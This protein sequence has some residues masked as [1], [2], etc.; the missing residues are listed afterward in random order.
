M[1]VC[2]AALF[3]LAISSCTGFQTR[4]FKTAKAQSRTR[5]VLQMLRNV[6]RPELLIFT[7]AL[8]AQDR[9]AWRL[10]DEATDAD[11][12][13]ALLIHSTSGKND[14]AFAFDENS[15]KHPALSIKDMRNAS[16][17][18]PPHPGALSALR[19]SMTVAP[20]GFGGSG[21]FGRRT[22]DPERPPLA[23]YCIVISDTTECALAARAAGMR[24]IGV[25]PSFESIELFEAACDIVFPS[26]GANEEQDEFVYFDDLFTPGS[27]WLN[28]ATPRDLAG[29]SVDPDT[30][31]PAQSSPN[32]IRDESKDISR[33]EIEKKVAWDQ[34]E[35]DDG[36]AATD[37]IDGDEGA[38]RLLEILRDIQGPSKR[39]Q[40]L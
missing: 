7:S 36:D 14:V 40:N 6:D 30:G 26:L 3:I 22:A 12:P 11:C 20:E 5:G 4:Y 27:F 15:K 28:P 9:G 24:C 38:A 8:V 35:I 29:N 23:S 13:S 16:R 21:G 18:P 33:Q 34:M 10:L 31:E 39:P 37:D 17:M 1:L 19:K 25:N 32:V 2:H